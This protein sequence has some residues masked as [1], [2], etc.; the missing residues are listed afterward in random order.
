[1]RADDTSGSN[2]SSSVAIAVL[3]TIL[4]ISVVISAVANILQGLRHNGLKKKFKTLEQTLAIA[5]A[6]IT[7][8]STAVL[9]SGG[10]ASVGTGAAATQPLLP[11]G[12]TE[13]SIELRDPTTAKFKKTSDQRMPSLLKIS[14]KEE[15]GQSFCF[16]NILDYNYDE[17]QPPSVE[18]G[19][20][21][22]ASSNG[23]LAQPPSRHDPS[24]SSNAQAP[25]CQPPVT[26]PLT[27]SEGHQFDLP[28]YSTNSEEAGKDI[29]KQQ[30][31]VNPRRRQGSQDRE[32]PRDQ[33]QPS[34]GYNDSF[35]CGASRERDVRDGDARG[36][37][38]SAQYARGTGDGDDNAQYSSN[39]NGKLHV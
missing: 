26:A 6:A 27:V 8:Q 18:A 13:A 2:A 17:L 19:S 23:F 7:D 21:H 5:R 12:H 36:A 35:R 4:V 32:V 31:R 9:A 25:S 20:R 11:N 16:K 38:S 3:I 30:A 24:D 33:H 14:T 1:M 39:D 34:G 15:D 28:I 22:D 37:S 10:H 29:L